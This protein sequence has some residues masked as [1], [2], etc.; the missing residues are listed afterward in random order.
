M[1]SLARELMDQMWIQMH[2]KNVS[3]RVKAMTPEMAG[4]TALV[5]KDA[6]V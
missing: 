4:L 6:D 1:S 3:T 5:V 2:Q